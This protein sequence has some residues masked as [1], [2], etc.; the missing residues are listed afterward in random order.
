MSILT[1]LIFLVV[2]GVV[3]YLINKIPMDGTIKQI[4]NIL[5]IILIIV[6]LLKAFGIWGAMG[7]VKV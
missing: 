4:I 6:F 1:I 2:V 7:N 3:L 5:V